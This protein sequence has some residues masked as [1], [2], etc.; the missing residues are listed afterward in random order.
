MMQSWLTG[1]EKENRVKGRLLESLR[2]NL[3]SAG[4]MDIVFLGNSVLGHS[5][6]HN[7]FHEL[8]KYQ[9]YQI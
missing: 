4:K 8:T 9:V 5:L 6:D 1:V 3:G 2:G 7:L